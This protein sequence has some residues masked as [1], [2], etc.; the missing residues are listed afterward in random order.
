MV[1]GECLG[2]ILSP[3]LGNQ[4]SLPEGGDINASIWKITRSLPGWERTVLS[5][6]VQ[7]GGPGVSRNTV[8]AGCG[9]RD[10]ERG[11]WRE[12]WERRSEP[13]RC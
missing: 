13:A 3:D 4:G 8:W 10:G 7:R 6:A 2:S 11:A 1:M 9:I 12:M 5:E